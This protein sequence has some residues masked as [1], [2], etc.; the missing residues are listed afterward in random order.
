MCY[1]SVYLSVLKKSPT[2]RVYSCVPSKCI[3]IREVY[4]AE[5]QCSTIWF[6]Y[7]RKYIA[8]V[9]RINGQLLIF[10]HKVLLLPT[11]IEQNLWKMDFKYKIL[12]KKCYELNIEQ[13]WE[14]S[15]LHKSEKLKIVNNKI[16]ILITSILPYLFLSIFRSINQYSLP[17]S[18]SP[19]STYSLPPSTLPPPISSSHPFSLN[20]S[21]SSYLSFPLPSILPP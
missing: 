16:V 9:P 2:T 21:F 12:N 15:A 5:V 18:S 11:W 14:L 4:W 7:K 1:L 13:Q 20:F 17:P 6:P 3:G 19:S 10:Q 8:A